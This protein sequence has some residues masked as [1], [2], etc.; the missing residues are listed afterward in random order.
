L[1][2]SR[3]DDRRDALLPVPPAAVAAGVIARQELA[4]GVPHGPANV[5]AAEVIS[6]DD[7]VSPA[8]HDELHPQ[9][10]NVYLRERD[11]IRL[12]AARTLS[13]I[14]SLRQLSVRRLLTMIIRALE[15]QMQWVVFEPNN[16][17]LRFEVRLA[18]EN[19]LRQLFRLG[20]FKGATEDQ[21]F[22]VTC[23]ET[24]NTPLSTDDGRLVAEIGVAP[25]EP[26]E[27]IVLSLARDADGTLTLKEK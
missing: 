13:R 25:A 10:I 17:A 16:Q 27:F 15:Q 2:V 18:I 20:A 22:F 19:Y 11:G 14:P 3:R 6:L 23:D 5:L 8:R 12:T 4:F 21:A 7:V 9:G 24:N 26:L 1:R